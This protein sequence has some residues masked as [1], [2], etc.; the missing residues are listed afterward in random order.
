MPAPTKAKQDPTRQAG[1]RDRAAAALRRRIRVARREALALF[2][3]V[4]YAI[5][6]EGVVV[7]ATVPVY[8]YQITAEELAVLIAAVQAAIGD[9]LLETSLNRMPPQWWWKTHIELPYRQ[10]AAREVVEFN[11]L[12]TQHLVETRTQL[13]STVQRLDVGQALHSPQ[14]QQALDKV[15]VRNFQGMKGLSDTTAK[16]VAQV[17][18][19]GIAAGK[20]ASEIAADINKRFGVALSSAERTATTEVNWAY[21][22]GRLD[23]TDIAGEATGLRAGVLHLSALTPGTRETHGERHGNGYT[24]AAQRQW[25]NTGANRIRCQCSTRTVLIDEEGKVIDAELQE[26]VQLERQFFDT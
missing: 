8:D 9:Q 23:A 16:Q 19:A 1:N 2:E 22:D 14:Y 10:G 15:Y 5:K 3:E 25:W 17:I 20:P 4:P 6:R 24:T 13:G 18:D 11:R 21:N 12:V 26:E 7:N